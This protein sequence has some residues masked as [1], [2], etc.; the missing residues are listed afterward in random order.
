MKREFYALYAI[1]FGWCGAQFFYQ[2]RIFAGIISILF[3]WT[4][5]P[6]L[7]G[8]IMGLHALTYNAEEFDA[9]YKRN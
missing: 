6:S 2:N 8:F 7:V 3:S 4:G 1:L 9:N 5:I